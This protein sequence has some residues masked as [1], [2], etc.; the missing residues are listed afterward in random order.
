[1]AVIRDFALGQHYA[2]LAEGAA[3]CEAN[4]SFQRI[5][6]VACITMKSVMIEPIVTARPVKPFKKNAYENATK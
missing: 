2:V 5:F 1:M 6:P 3:L 4:L